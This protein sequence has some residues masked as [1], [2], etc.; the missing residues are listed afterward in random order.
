MAER[1]GSKG[2]TL[3]TTT[4][5][6]S[7]HKFIALLCPLSRLERQSHNP[8]LFS[9]CSDGWSAQQWTHKKLRPIQNV[10]QRT[11]ACVRVRYQPM[12]QFSTPANQLSFHHFSEWHIYHHDHWTVDQTAVIFTTTHK[13][14]SLFVC[15]LFSLYLSILLT[16][17]YSVWMHVY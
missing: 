6:T 5:I 12:P 4:N 17:F 1:F 11:S 9:L 15:L 14:E 2:I 10:T 16:Y 3:S 8:I 7:G 13:V